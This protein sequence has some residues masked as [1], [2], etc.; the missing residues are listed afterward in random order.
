MK[1]EELIEEIKLTGFMRIRKEEQKGWYIYK[2]GMHPG[3]CYLN[4]QGKWDYH[5]N[6]HHL[7]S[8]LEALKFCYESLEKL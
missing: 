6:C 8:A 4:A 3:K 5:Q 1:E 7:S 2:M